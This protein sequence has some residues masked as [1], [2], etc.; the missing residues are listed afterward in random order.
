MRLPRTQLEDALPEHGGGDTRIAERRPLLLVPVPAES[1]WAA[2]PR[3]EA[4]RASLAGVLGGAAADAPAGAAS[5]R[6]REDGPGGADGHAPAGPAAHAGQD[7][8][9]SM[10]VSDATGQTTADDGDSAAARARRDG[11]PAAAAGQ[12]ASSAGAAPPGA[13][14]PGG[15]CM[16]YVSR[17]AVL[18]AA[19]AGAADAQR[20]ALPHPVRPKMC[21]AA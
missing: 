14:L 17:A 2:A 9:M 20:G 15:C 7:L 10:M 12:E 8:S 6:Q 16:A 13:D 1:A 5:K 21:T 3:A 4:A 18:A 19:A 11:G